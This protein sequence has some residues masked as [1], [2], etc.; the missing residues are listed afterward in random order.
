MF[1]AGAASRC[2]S[3]EPAPTGATRCRARFRSRRRSGNVCGVVRALLWD[4][5]DTLVDERWML[6]APT[7]CPAWADAWNA[8]MALH[9][10]DWNV[11]R[12]KEADI[13]RA[14]SDATGL[15][16]H[17]VAAHARQ[18]CASVAF[19]ARTFSIVRERRLP[20]ALVT[21][22]PDLF[23]ERVAKQ[24]DLASHFDAVVVS[25]VEGTA[26]KTALCDVALDRLG[27][28]G[29]RAAGLLIDNRKDLVDA[30]TRAGGSGYWYRGDEAFAADPPSVLA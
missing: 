1:A 30:W 9:A 10:D 8:V 22:N 7:S 29:D 6:T 24:Y 20:Q 15:S 3:V 17:E 12:M 16:E 18:C 14:L 2:D 5:G 23:V 25:A 11:G 28:R 4:F 26:D 13:F 21:V 27:L 19:H